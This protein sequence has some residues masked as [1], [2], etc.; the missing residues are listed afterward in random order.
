M[1]WCNERDGNICFE[2][3]KNST[4]LFENVCKISMK[5]GLERSI[6]LKSYF[7]LHFLFIII[8]LSI[9]MMMDWVRDKEACVMK[10]FVNML[11]MMK[12]ESNEIAIRP[13][14]F[15]S[16]FDL[17]ISHKIIW[18][19]ICRWINARIMWIFRM[20][21]KMRNLSC[22]CVNTLET[23]R[24]GGISARPRKHVTIQICFSFDHFVRFGWRAQFRDSPERFQKHSSCD[25]QVVIQCWVTVDYDC[26]GLCY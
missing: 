20:S 19:A 23:F 7:F 4:K 21:K 5:L 2:H 14:F 1:E 26:Y 24:S 8:T 13:T 11:R 12:N 22:I 9:S 16:Y 15:Y 18:N 25:L 6:S 10:I 3:F 17:W